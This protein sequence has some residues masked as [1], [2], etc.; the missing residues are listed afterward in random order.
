[1]S[2]VSQS[3]RYKTF[4]VGDGAPT[5]AVGADE[6]VAEPAELLAATDTRIVDATSADTRRYVVPVA[7]ATGAQEAPAESQ[8]CH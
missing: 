6:A 4:P 3:A 7:P 1:V 5:T 2:I 8:R